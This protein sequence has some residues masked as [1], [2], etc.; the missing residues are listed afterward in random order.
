MKNQ[1]C[2]PKTAGK[3]DFNFA[4]SMN[5]FYLLCLYKRKV[6]FIGTGKVQERVCE[7]TG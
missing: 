1:S 4:G 2:M 7:N 3:I 5:Y 6:Y